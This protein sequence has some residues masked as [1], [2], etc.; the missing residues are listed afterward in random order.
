MMGD[1][2]QR[3]AIR[4]RAGSYLFLLVSMV[5]M[6]VLRPFLED[7]IRLSF[8]M[9]IFFSTILL[10]AVYAV[11]E[12]RRT[13]I[14]AVIMALPVFIASWGSHVI[15]APALQYIGKPLS[16]LFFF[17][18][19]VV[20]LGHIFRQKEVKADTVMG[21]VCVY[22]IIGLMW[23]VGYQL[24]EIVLPGSFSQAQGKQMDMRA[25]VYFSYV[26]LTTLG[27]G[28][29]TPVSSAARNLSV[30]EAITGQLYLAVLIARLIGL[31]RFRGDR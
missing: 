14:V 15:E 17:Y 21:A 6:F 7:F 30:L 18:I 24:L 23:G 19:S 8:L 16:I 13:L 29:I 26:T 25:S 12:K 1:K 20:I 28:D 9:D 11:S 31:L 5:L 4:F 2:L 27:Y 22:F 10:A 3:N